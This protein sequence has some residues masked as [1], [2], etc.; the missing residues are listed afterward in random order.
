VQLVVL[1]RKESED[2]NKAKNVK[3]WT[4]TVTAPCEECSATATFTVEASTEPLAMEKASQM[5]KD[6]DIEQWEYSH[7][8]GLDLEA[9]AHNIEVIEEK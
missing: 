1:Y 3:K 7:D 2:M 8:E 9:G 5:V 6:N 4:V